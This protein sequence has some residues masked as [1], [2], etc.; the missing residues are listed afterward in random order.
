MGNLAQT[1]QVGPI[2]SQASLKP[3]KLSQLSSKM[4]EGAMS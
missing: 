3:E 2:E 4:E 1:I